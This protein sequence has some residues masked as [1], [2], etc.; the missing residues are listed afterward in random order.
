MQ[1]QVLQTDQFAAP[2]AAQVAPRLR[3]LVPKVMQQVKAI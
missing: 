2:A 1:E 3:D